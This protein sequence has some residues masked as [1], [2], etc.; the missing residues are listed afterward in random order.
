METLKAFLNM[1]LE[2]LRVKAKR[3]EFGA[4]EGQWTLIRPDGTQFVGKSPFAAIRAEADDRIPADVGL[5]RI[6]LGI[7]DD[8]DMECEP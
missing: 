6:A 1:P 8:N 3:G 7:R 4:Q 2:E 5:A